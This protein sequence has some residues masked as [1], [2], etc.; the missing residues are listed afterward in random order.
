MRQHR[1]Q[2]VSLRKEYDIKEVATLT[3]EKGKAKKIVSVGKRKS[4]TQ[5]EKGIQYSSSDAMKDGVASCDGE[6]DD[7]ASCDDQEDV[8]ATNLKFD[9]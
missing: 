1:Q 7:V 8:V 5:K 6:K 4:N 2:Q 9:V 3:G